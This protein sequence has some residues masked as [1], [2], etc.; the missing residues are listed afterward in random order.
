[1]GEKRKKTASPHFSWVLQQSELAETD[2]GKKT[3]C[4]VKWDDGCLVQDIF[5]DGGEGTEAK[6]EKKVPAK[7]QR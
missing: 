5:I 7:C 6:K 4:S 3:R 2:L 1:M